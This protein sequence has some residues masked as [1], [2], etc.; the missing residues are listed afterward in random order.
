M[1]SVYLAETAHRYRR[2]STLVPESQIEELRKMLREIIEQKGIRGIAEE[3][4]KDG[5]PFSRNRRSVGKQLADQLGLAHDYSDPDEA[6]WKALSIEKGK[7]ADPKRERYWLE[8]LQSFV[9]FP[10][11]FILGTRHFESFTRLLTQS[12]FQV[13]EV[14][15]DWKPSSPS[16]ADAWLEWIERRDASTETS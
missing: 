13:F 12:G 15:R 9:E 2:D 7:Q 16:E 8:R 4:S 6:T 3:M 1:R 11:L 5:L 14:V 10:V